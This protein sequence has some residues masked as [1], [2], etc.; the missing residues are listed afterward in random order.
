MKHIKDILETHA[1]AEYIDVQ[2]E[3][4]RYCEKEVQQR[5]KLSIQELLEFEP[6]G[7]KLWINISGN[8]DLSLVEQIAKHFHI[9]ELIVEDIVSRNERPKIDVM[10]DAIFIVI[11]MLGY[12]QKLDLFEAE[13]LCIYLTT[14]L[15]I[16]FQ[17]VKGDNFG[18]VRNHLNRMGRACHLGSDYL[19]YMILDLVVDEYFLGMERIGEWI[20]DLEDQI[21][22]KTTYKR[23]LEINELKKD[24]NLMRKHVWP[25]RDLVASL[26]RHDENSI[27]RPE[28]AMYFRDIHDHT[29]QVIDTIETYRERMASLRDL[30]AN[31]LNYR[32]NDIMKTLTVITTLFI[33]LTFVTGLYGMN[34]DHMPELHW[35]LGYPLVL[36]AMATGVVAMTFYFRRKGWL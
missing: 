30:Y 18:M 17:D 26:Q 12:N 33:P 1:E 3:V 21:L 14:D 31:Q 4:F 6:A 11:K 15:L 34:F 9:H 16:T 23:N 22:K 5:E 24:I 2:A 10:D 13:Q 36:A 25:V 27:M 29:V 19:A 35:R 32:M 28:T 7:Q 20:D 8:F